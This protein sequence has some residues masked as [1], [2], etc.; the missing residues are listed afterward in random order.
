MADAAYACGRGAPSPQAVS[1]PGASRD[2]QGPARIAIR[3]QLW[4]DSSD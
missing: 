1:G 4:Q 3:A 2:R